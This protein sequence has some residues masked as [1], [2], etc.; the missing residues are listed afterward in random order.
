MFVA[1]NPHGMEENQQNKLQYLRS[2]AGI[3]D[4]LRSPLRDICLDADRRRQE[5]GRGKVAD[6]RPVNKSI[7]RELL[8][9]YAG[10]PLRDR[11][12]V[13]VRMRNLPLAALDR[14][15]PAGGE[16][17]EI[18]CGHGVIA[19]YL[20]LSS[21]GRR[22]FGIDIAADKIACAVGTVGDRGNISYAVSLFLDQPAREYDAIV[23]SDVLYL[24]DA[25]E[26][27][28]TLAGCRAQLKQ[29]GVCVIKTVDFSS[30]WTLLRARVHERMMRD[31]L[32]LTRGSRR[33]DFRRM[34]GWRELLVSAGFTFHVES[35]PA[36]R[37]FLAKPSWIF[38]CRQSG[39]PRGEGS[40]AH[41]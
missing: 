37:P 24:M 19:N 36:T 12:H 7:E 31:L 4:H 21:P 30:R 10:A 14:V 22:V 34:E 23:L 29:G 26:Q 17:L 16:I 1:V 2:S 3:S 35:I 11:F 20:A 40:G 28:L 27:R 41:P 33:F 39:V 8:S 9:L 5:K 38:V 32:H 15:V 6:S 25:E 18:G 13:R